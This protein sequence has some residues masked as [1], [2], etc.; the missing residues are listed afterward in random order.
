MSTSV[1]SAL[2]N[3]ISQ[4]LGANQKNLNRS[5]AALAAGNRLAAS[6]SIDIAALSVATGLSTETTTLRSAANNIAQAA[7][8]LQV[9]DGGLSETASILDRMQALSVQANSGSLSDAARKGLN[10]E[11]QNLYQELNRI[12][13]NTNFNGVNLL[14]GSLSTSSKIA[15]D[16]TPGTQASGALNFAVNV[17]VGQTINLNGVSLV[18]GT[19]FTLGGTA[20]QTVSNLADALNADSRFDGYSFTANGNLLEITAD[21][22]GEAGNQF[23]INRG[24]STA[25]FTV[26]SGDALTGANVYSLQGGTN[27]GLSAGDTSASGTVNDAILASGTGSASSTQMLFSTASDIQAG[28]T[29]SIDNGEGGFTTFTFTAGAPASATDIQIGSTLEETLQNAAGAINNYSG[30]GDYGTRQL[31]ATVEGNTLKLTGNTNG[32]LTDV[33]GA[34]LDVALGTTGGSLSNAQLNNGS[35]GGVDVTGVTNSAFIGKVQGFEASYTGANQ[36]TVSIDV[37]GKTYTADIANTNSATNQTV[38]FTSEDGGYFDV[39]LQGGKGQAVNSQA[40]ADTLANRLDA[41]FSG[42]NFSQNRDVSSFKPTGSLIGASMQL[43]GDDFSGLNVE[44]VQVNN[45]IGGVGSVAITINGE[46]YRSGAGLGKTIGAGESVTLTSTSNPN[47]T[48]TFTNGN[49]AIDLSTSSGAESFES[50]L[51]RDLGVPGNQGAGFQIGSTPSDS[52]NLTI[53][54][55]SADALF[56]GKAIDILSQSGAAQAFSAI[57][58]AKDYV[59]SQRADV[60]SFQSALDFAAAN[61]QSAIQN[62]EAARAALEDTDFAAESTNNA[63][64]TV[65]RQAQIALLAQSNKMGSNLLRL[66]Q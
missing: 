10:T 40:D 16:A 4:L 5:V 61:V 18:G 59:T 51:K 6:A 63:K 17:G 20:G 34:A 21:A 19:D 30:A 38:R 48:L 66:V 28:D 52:V 45:A 32:T 39:T 37:G 43:K 65:Q 12:S 60:G 13:G 58:A 9:A 64:L 55:L 42:L 41:A 23:T 49:N 2:Q 27:A 7:S 33:N 8:F 31:T 44:D 47:H 56:N 50:A 11:F 46:T 26:A 53:G 35:T 36:A 24:A 3:S 62:Q 25:A 29:I 1:T 15:T 14:D 22:A 54:N 57:A